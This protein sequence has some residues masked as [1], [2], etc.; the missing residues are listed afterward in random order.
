MPVQKDVVIV[1]VCVW[2]KKFQNRNVLKFS[3]I[4]ETGLTKN[5]YIGGE[6]L[7]IPYLAELIHEAHVQGLNTRLSTNG[8]LLD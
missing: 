1:L 3:N 7:L 4:I 8:I 2:N 6:P 5:R